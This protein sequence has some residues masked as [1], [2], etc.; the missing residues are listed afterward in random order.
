[1]DNFAFFQFIVCL[2]FFLCLYYGN[3]ISKWINI[4]LLVYYGI[5]IILLFVFLRFGNKI[6]NGKN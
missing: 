2:I 3:T 6:K 4:N 1:M 5:L